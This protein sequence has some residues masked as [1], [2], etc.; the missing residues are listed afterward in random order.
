MIS[1]MWAVVGTVAALGVPLAYAGVV[2]AI[3][4]PSSP[5]SRL[6]KAVGLLGLAYAVE[7]MATY[8]YV[9]CMSGVVDRVAGRLKVMA[10][11]ALLAQEV[12]FFDLAGSAEVRESKDYNGKR[13]Q[14]VA[15]GGGGL[16]R[17]VRLVRISYDCLRPFFFP[18]GPR[19]C[20]MPG[21]S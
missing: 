20:G 2:T 7:P 10:F 1:V 6:T 11:R 15:G 9:R 4:E 14:V 8:F 16:G 12:A 13:E 21:F 3:L 18:C 19:R 17:G 5:S